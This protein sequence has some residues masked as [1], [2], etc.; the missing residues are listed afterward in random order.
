ME[1]SETLQQYCILFK[2]EF[3]IKEPLITSQYLEEIY[4][5]KIA[6]KFIKSVKL[7][8]VTLHNL[9]EVYKQY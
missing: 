9:K 6:F 4:S 7:L 8:F 5:K 1:C 3:S 2:D